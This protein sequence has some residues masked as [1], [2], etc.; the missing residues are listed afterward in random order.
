MPWD[1]TRTGAV[2]SSRGPARWRARGA[3]AAEAGRAGEAG[4]GSARRR[5]AQAAEDGGAEVAGSGA[6]TPGA[7]GRGGAGGRTHPSPGRRWDA[8]DAGLDRTLVPGQDPASQRLGAADPR[9]RTARPQRGA[10]RTARG[11]GPERGCDPLR[12]DRAGRP[13]GAGWGRSGGRKRWFLHI[14]GGRSWCRLRGVWRHSA[15]L[16]RA[17]AAVGRERYAGATFFSAASGRIR[18]EECA[19]ASKRSVF[20]STP[21]PASPPRSAREPHLASA[22]QHPSRSAMGRTISTVRC[23]RTCWAVR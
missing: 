2:S 13:A 22:G 3:G 14:I 12:Q 9:V 20:V 7:Y 1:R 16:L 17:G 11:R 8:E 23:A 15:V 6:V 4:E 5:G 19:G 21:E 18:S 10:R